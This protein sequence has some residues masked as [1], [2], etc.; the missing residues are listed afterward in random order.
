MRKYSTVEKMSLGLKHL[1]SFLAVLLSVFDWVFAFTSRI[2]KL[3]Y[4][5]PEVCFKLFSLVKQGM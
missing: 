3:D 5:I 2:R 1:D 4:L